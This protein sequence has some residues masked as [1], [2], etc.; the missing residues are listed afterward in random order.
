VRRRHCSGLVPERRARLTLGPKDARDLPLRRPINF[1]TE[2]HGRLTRDPQLQRARAQVRLPS[3]GRRP[4]MATA[5]M[6]VAIGKAH[7]KGS[8]IRQRGPPQTYSVCTSITLSAETH[9]FTN[10]FLGGLRVSPRVP[11][12]VPRRL[13]SQCIQYLILASAHCRLPRTHLMRPSLWSRP[14]S[15]RTAPVLRRSSMGLRTLV[16]SHIWLAAGAALRSLWCWPRLASYAAPRSHPKMRLA[17]PVAKPSWLAAK[18][19][20]AQSAPRRPRT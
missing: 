6:K 17:S 16:R 1:G 10:A 2:G 5:A 13:I 9:H 20:S 18:L 3:T 11:N 19:S 12:R 4:F 14:P 7:S 15:V 8:R